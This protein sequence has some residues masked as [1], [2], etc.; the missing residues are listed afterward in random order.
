MRCRA[1]LLAGGIAAAAI[2]A[3]PAQAAVVITVDKSTQQVTVAVDGATRFQWKVST[4]RIGHDTPNGT[5]HALW[6]DADHHSKT[7]D[8]APMP[9]S[10]FFTDQGH[11]LHGTFAARQLGTPASHGCVRLDRDNATRLFALVKGEGLKNTTIVITGNAAEA[12]AHRPAAPAT[13]R[14]DV[15]PAAP[16]RAPIAQPAPKPDTATMRS[17]ARDATFSPVRMYAQP[18]AQPTYRQ[19]FVPPYV[20]TP[21]APPNFPPFPRPGVVFGD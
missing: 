4:G 5:F 15:V 12:R 9:H 21:V 16:S 13:A 3:V 14:A 8:D 19:A 17:D 11:A 20:A 1:M 7:Y 10:I 2:A 18:A 6:L